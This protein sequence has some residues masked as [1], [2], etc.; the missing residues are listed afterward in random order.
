M[1][2]AQEQTESSAATSVEQLTG[3]S[4]WRISNEKHYIT[5]SVP[6]VGKPLKPM[7]A[8][9]S[10]LERSRQSFSGLKYSHVLIRLLEALSYEAV[11]D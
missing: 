9:K 1:G 11:G 3:K 2:S 8:T 10:M 7:R 5:C 4:T 6:I